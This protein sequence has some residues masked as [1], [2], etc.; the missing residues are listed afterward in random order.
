MKTIQSIKSSKDVE[1]NEIRRVDDK[2]AHNMVGTSWKYI[3][4]TQ[5][6]KETKVLVTQEVTEV[7]VKKNKK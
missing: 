3:S 1:L 4:K 6:K 5:W 2:T 7:K